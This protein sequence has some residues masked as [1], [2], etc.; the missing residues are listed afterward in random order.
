LSIRN[1]I[2]EREKIVVCLVLP[3]ETESGVGRFT[4]DGPKMARNRGRE[5]KMV[6]RVL[7]HGG[8]RCNGLSLE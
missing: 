7:V 1:K 2:K 3:V 6:V 5:E 8:S 4:G